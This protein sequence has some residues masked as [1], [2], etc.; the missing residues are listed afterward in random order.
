MTQSLR[1]SSSSSS[2]TKKGI[3]NT[4]L[5]F[6]IGAL[7]L[8]GLTRRSRTGMT[9]AA[10]SSLLLFKAAQ[11]D[12]ASSKEY[13]AKSNFLVN[14][15]PEQAYRL[16]RDLEKLPRFMAHIKSVRMLDG[17]TSEWT[18][19]GPMGSEVRWKAEIVEDRPNERISW[20]SLPGAEIENR[21]SVEFHPGPQNRGTMMAA[22]IRYGLPLGAAARALIASLGKD[23]QFML[24]E[25]LRRFKALL[26]AGEVPTT[27]GQPHGPRGLHGGIE[28]L[29]FRER[30][31][32]AE[33]QAA[34]PLHRTA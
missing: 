12:F 24:R 22:Q 31:N 30:T 14:A 16:W 10:A 21:G 13:M 3:Q 23:P 25:D 27:V 26:E 17:A 2:S 20:R 29:L 28:Q 18:A 11:S 19:S 7:A 33:P 4:G 15:S 9:L 1:N 6:S 32:R 5:L 34:T 8:Y